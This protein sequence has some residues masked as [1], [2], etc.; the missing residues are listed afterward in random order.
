[1]RK[2]FHWNRGYENSRWG[3][4]PLHRS[5]QIVPRLLLLVCSFALQAQD[6]PRNNEGVPLSELPEAKSPFTLFAENNP[7]TGKSA[8]SFDGKEIPPVIRSSPGS[9]IKLEYLN[10]MSTDSKEVCVD[11]PCMNMTNLHFHGLHVSPDA[12]QD[13]VISMLAMPG[14]SLR[15]VVDIPEDEPP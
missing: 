9:K 14:E 5:W 10:R 12:P 3:S 7:V 2:S 1:M 13:D 6:V 4:S 15:Y 8:F 11:G